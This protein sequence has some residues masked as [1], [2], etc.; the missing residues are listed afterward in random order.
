M[1]LKICRIDYFKDSIRRV[2]HRNARVLL[3]VGGGQYIRSDYKKPVGLCCKMTKNDADEVWFSHFQ[4]EYPGFGIGRR[5]K[6][7]R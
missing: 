4:I 7:C 3:I 1:I 5:F 2:N 6:K